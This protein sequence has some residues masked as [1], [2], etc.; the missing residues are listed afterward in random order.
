MENFK[1][2]PVAIILI[3]VAALSMGAVAIFSSK[4]NA[5]DEPKAVAA[6][7]ALTVA[8]ALPQQ[9][10]LPVRL[11]ANGNITA[12]QEAII[13]SESNGLRL[14]QVRVNV[15]DQVRAGQVLAVFYDGSVQA[16]MAQARASLLEAEAN[17]FDAA[18]NAARARTLESSGALSAQ[19]I[20]QYRT[21]EQTAKARAEAARAVLGA[22]QLRGRQTQVLAPDNGVISARTATVGAVVGAGTELFRL[23]RGGRLEWRAEVTSA[24][25]GRITAGTPATV[26]AASGAQLKGRVRMI[27]PTVDPQTRAALVYVDLQVPASMMSPAK[28]GMFARGEFDLGTTPAL[29]VPQTALVVRDGFSYVFRLNPDKRISQLKVQTGRLAGDRVEISAGL[30]A[31]TRVIVSGAGFLNDGDLVRVSDDAAQNQPVA[32]TKPAQAAIK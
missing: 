2:K 12:W 6:R 13:G 11:S 19:Q 22:Q 3:A 32:P 9:L 1:L 21:A 25:L 16:E 10:S 5:D 8:T 17:A 26:V 30:A 7:P 14:A 31:D 28:A 18:D 24:E 23:I 29:T 27:A 4:S 15:G 20:N